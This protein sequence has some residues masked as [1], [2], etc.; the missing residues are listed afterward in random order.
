MSDN[1]EANF[2]GAASSNHA[3]TMFSYFPTLTALIPLG[4]QRASLQNWVQ[5]GHE[6]SGTYG[7]MT[8]A[9]GCCCDNYGHCYREIGTHKQCPADFGA[10]DGIEIP[11]AIG[12]FVELHCSHDSSMR[13]TAAMAAQPFI[14]YVDYTGNQTFMKGTAYPFIREVAAFYASYLRVDS[15]DGLYG[16]PFGC[17]QELCSGRQSGDRHPQKDD[18]IDLA[19]SRWIFAKA[20]D[21]GGRLNESTAVLEKWRQIAGSLKPYPL[22]DQ[23]QPPAP[24]GKADMEDW[25][26]AS[27]CSG[28]SEAVNTDINRSQIMWANADWPIANFAPIHPTGQVGLRSDNHTKTLAR[29]TIWLVK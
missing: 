1:V 4:R 7:Q 28:F 8:E 13:S 16:V 20:I 25:C 19:Y 26:A 3:D 6:S 15:V 10:F 9:M 14:D 5:G 12:G 18:T 11:S 21:W 2:Y 17:A 29:N 22:T 23:Y 24:K 27:N